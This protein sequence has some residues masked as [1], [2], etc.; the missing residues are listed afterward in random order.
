MRLLIA[1]DEVRLTRALAAFFEKNKYIVDTVNN[2]IDALEQALSGDY[3]VIILDIMMPRMNGIEVVR[4]LRRRNLSTPVLLL[5]AKSEIADRIE[6]L[7]SGADDYVMKPFAIDE[8]LA[9]V[10]ALM[11]RKA[12]FTADVRH[13][14]NVALNLSTYEISVEE[15]SV[16]LGSRELQMMEM[17]MENPRHIITTAQFMEH[18]WGWD[19]NVEVS[20]VWVCV[21]NLRKKLAAIGARA[22]IRTAR[23][24]GYSLE[25][26][27]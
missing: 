3:D 5:T 26:V 16:R 12:E 24:I 27:S 21:S 6:G 4:S 15:N 10:R 9:R 7:E 13:F 8:L 23:G 25:A 11:R 20:V 14:G 17:L 2:G 1:E 19:S 22:D 18:I